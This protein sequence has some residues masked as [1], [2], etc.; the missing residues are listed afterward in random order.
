M[1]RNYFKVALRN[2]IRYKGFSFINILGLAIGIT[3]CLVIGVFV[4]DELQYDKNIAGGENIYR[5]YQE[6]NDKGNITY[7]PCVPPAFA[8][9]LKNEYPE[10][11]TTA[12]VLMLGDKF[13]MEGETNKGYEE[14]GWFTE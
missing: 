6:R 12:R 9:Y 2:L 11:D 13:F 4:Y 14:K 5:V 10:V 8:T 3:G 7:A 1:L